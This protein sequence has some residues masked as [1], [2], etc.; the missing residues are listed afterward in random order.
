MA[1]V[2]PIAVERDAIQL[3]S[4]ASAIAEPV[5]EANYRDTGFAFDPA[6]QFD[7]RS[8]ALRIT[9][10][11]DGAIGVIR[12]KYQASTREGLNKSLV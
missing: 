4:A 6:K 10:D 9:S 12:A 8:A 7:G 2:A 3:H 11:I 5:V 1:E